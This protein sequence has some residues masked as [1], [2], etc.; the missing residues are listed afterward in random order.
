VNIADAD[1]P[2]SSG[3]WPTSWTI[4]PSVSKPRWEST[5]VAYN[6]KIYLFG[7]WMS[8]S[9]TATQQVDMY[10]P[11]ANKWTTLG[12]MPVPHTHSEVAVDEAHGVFYFA[13]GLFGSF[14]GVVT[15]KV[16]KYDV[17]TNKYTEM[18][19]LPS[20]HEGGSLSLVNNELHY[21]GGAGD[22][23]E[24]D[25]SD[26]LVLDLDNQAAG[27]QS[28][29]SM[30]DP[31][32]H[33]AQVVLD[34]KIICIGGEFGH[35]QFHIQQDFVDSYDP[36]AKT[37]TRLE[38]I[39]QKKSHDE[40]GTFIAPNGHIISAGGQIDDYG[41]TANVIDYDPA[42]GHWT[43]I[44]TL[45]KALMGPVVQQLGDK[46]IVTTGNDGKGPITSLWIGDLS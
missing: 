5:S 38:S 39:P 10:D 43:T 41:Q 18:D 26:H 20:N 42:T 37:W 2:V 24:V 4:G 22:E 23:R 19:S 45:P 34:G 31:R 8:G 27:W 35:D 3:D 1:S 21:I 32:D 7:G 12:Y 36:I 9:S 16:F 28:A 6:G 30:P 40:S 14:P 17:A 15:N 33:F 11:A 25:I 44:G 29:P 46:I 13:G